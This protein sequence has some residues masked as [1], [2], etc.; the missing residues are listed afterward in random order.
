MLPRQQCPGV[1]LAPIHQ[2]PVNLLARLPA[3]R[4]SQINE[5]TPAAWA[6]AKEK[7]VSQAA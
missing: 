2:S 7:M 4:I 1:A 3:A 5:F 6:K